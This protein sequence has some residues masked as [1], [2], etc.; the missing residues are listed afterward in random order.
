[1][2]SLGLADALITRIG[3]ST[4]LQVRSLASSRRFGEADPMDAGR[5]LG[6][7]YIVEGTTQRGGDRIRVSARL[8]DVQ[9][10]RTLWSGTFDERSGNVFTLAGHA[11]S[12]R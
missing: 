9:K 12:A 6:A 7:R 3:S 8:I 2:L 1:M 11:R 5:R 10:D 4:S